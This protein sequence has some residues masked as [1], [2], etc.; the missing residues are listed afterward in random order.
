MKNLCSSRGGGID[1]GIKGG[2]GQS[3]RGKR[4]SLVRM[5]GHAGRWEH[6]NSLSLSGVQS[7]TDA[8]VCCSVPVL[9]LNT[10]FLNTT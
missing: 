4:E 8:L 2:E 1:E 10:H 6:S 3:R 9:G 5:D 7:I